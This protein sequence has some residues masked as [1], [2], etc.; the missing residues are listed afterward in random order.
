[1]EKERDEEG[2]VE[3]AG[4]V[5]GEK[6]LLVASRSSETWRRVTTCFSEGVVILRVSLRPDGDLLVLALASDASPVSPSLAW[7]RR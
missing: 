5:G 6:L 1:M 4:E 3:E 2:E 7:G